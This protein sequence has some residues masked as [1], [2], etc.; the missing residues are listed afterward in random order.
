MPPR[1]SLVLVACLAAGPAGAD[2]A[3]RSGG[4][5]VSGTLT[6]ADGRFAFHAP[7][8]TNPADLDLV[9]FAIKPP[10]P[11]PVALWHQVRL[12]PGEV[13]L[14]E[15]RSLDAT[16]LHVRPA[17]GGAL[18]VPRTAVERVTNA[19]GWR[20]VFF[21]TFDGDLARWTKSGE[22]RAASGQLV[23]DRAG[24]AIEGK[25]KD[26]SPAGR[27]AVGFRS[28]VT[29]SR[30][31]SLELGFVRD[32]KPAPVRVE[33]VGPGPRYVV[34]SPAK[35]SHEGALKRDAGSHRLAAEFDRDRL[36]LFLDD[37]VLRTQDTGPGELQSIRLVADGDGA[38]PAAVD[39]VLVARPEPAR[40][41]R[42]WADLT[43]DAVR[44]PDGDETFGTI[45]GAGPSGVAFEV[46]GRKLSLGWPEV[47]EFAFRRGPVA[48]RATEGEHVRVRVRSADGARDVLVGAVTAFD[49]KRLVLAHAVL[50]D[51]TI[52]RDRVEEIRFLFR[53]RRVPVDASP[54]H[55]GTRPAFGFAVP[56]PDG[57]RFAKA[58]TVDPVP[59]GGFVVVEAAR[60]SGSGPS[61]E[62]LLNGERLGELN[63]SA[64]RPDHVVR[65]YRFPVPASVWRKDNEVEVRLRPPEDGKRI[66]GVDLRALRL[67][68]NSK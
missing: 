31:L 33:L 51:L 37:L 42:S 47:A 49:H 32:G 57:L 14:A 36:H 21:D 63:R 64:D 68:V 48:E 22:P 50:G 20:P 4:T 3:V 67:E 2:E 23:F 55:L 59:A 10:V 62:V 7:D 39:N 45:L 19:P 44:S 29:T 38:E 15:V 16:H 12:G 46:K 9:R 28:A 54:H 27:V 30:R 35:A 6:F 53:G 41:P 34:T 8:G 26:S 40:E 58:V 24:Q 60:V 17:W 25:W 1:P 52:P 18:A 5:R 66:P 43:A 13:L 56:K 65:A 61:V 11:P